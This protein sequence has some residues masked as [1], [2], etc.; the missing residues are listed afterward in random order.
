MITQILK[1]IWN[2]KASNALMLLEI[3]LAFLVLFFAIAYTISQMNKVNRPIGFDY[4]NRAMVKMSHEV[5]NLD[6][7]AKAQMITNLKENLLNDDEVESVS[8]LK[9]VSPF[10]NNNS[11]S[12][13]DNMG[14]TISSQLMFVDLDYAKTMNVKPIR[15]RW[16]TEDDLLDESNPIIVNQQFMDEYFPEKDM[17]DSILDF[18]GERRIVGVVDE[19]RYLGAFSEVVPTL[20]VVQPHTDNYNNVVIK[21]KDQLRAEDEPRL[22]EIVAQSTGIATN[23]LVNLEESNTE[24]NR[25]NWIMLIAILSICGFL[26]VNVALG[27]FGVLSYNISK[28]KSEIGLRQA[29]GA[30][31]SDITKQFITEALILAGLA[32]VVGVFF[33]IQI[34]LLKV[35]EYPVTIFYQSIIYSSVIIL[36]L[37]LLCALLPSIQ[38]ATITPA[39]SLHED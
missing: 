21:M 2:K 32:V 36:V 10:Q 33:A 28:R 30:H 18:S 23:I 37:V 15:G 25:H 22:A 4:E 11:S 16:F 34:P 35:T 6:S 3:F 39:N 1:L 31:T 20:Y 19:I 14:F 27:L 5:F 29:L 38:A 24:R 26:C 12:S 8:F 9:H 17:L 13:S 7:T